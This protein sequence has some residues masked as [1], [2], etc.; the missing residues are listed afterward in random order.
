MLHTGC[1]SAAAGRSAAWGG[2]ALSG[3]WGI[4]LGVFRIVSLFLVGHVSALQVPRKLQVIVQVKQGW[5]CFVPHLSI[6]ACSVEA[7]SINQ[8]LC[9]LSIQNGSCYALTVIDALY[10]HMQTER[11]PRT[12]LRVVVKVNIPVIETHANKTPHY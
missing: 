6:L 5:G 9:T 4:L 3:S 12:T 11:P 7:S 10:Q 1:S 8:P 2:L